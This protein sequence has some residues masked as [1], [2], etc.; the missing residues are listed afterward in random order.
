MLLRIYKTA[1]VKLKKIQVQSVPAKEEKRT[2]EFRQKV[3]DLDQKL[4]DAANEKAHIVYIDETV[5]KGRDFKRYAYSLPGDKL[6][7]YDRTKYQVYQSVC[8]AISE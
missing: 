2:E 1:G 4:H 6:K 8:L 3:I 7:V 5:F